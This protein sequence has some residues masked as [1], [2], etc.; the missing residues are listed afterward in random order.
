MVTIFLQEKRPHVSVTRGQ[1]KRKGE[2]EILERGLHGAHEPVPFSFWLPDDVAFRNVAGNF[3]VALLV[4]RNGFSHQADDGNR[5]AKR[6]LTDIT[7]V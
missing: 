6:R 1:L 5:S 3:R 2:K 4:L 7:H